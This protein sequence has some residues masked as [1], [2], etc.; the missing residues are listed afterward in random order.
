MKKKTQ[1]FLSFVCALS[2]FFLGIWLGGRSTASSVLSPP[3]ANAQALG[4][5]YVWVDS[6]ATSTSSIDSFFTVQWN[7]IMIWPVGADLLVRI[8]AP[9]TASWSSRKWLRVDD[10]M[11]IT[12]GAASRLRRLEF[13]TI[14]GTG[15][16]FLSGLKKSSQY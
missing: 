14:S 8:G 2:L 13:K 4:Q 9:D 6:L 5:Q 7:D 1:L 3:S 15:A 16:L 10:G 12:I 11:A